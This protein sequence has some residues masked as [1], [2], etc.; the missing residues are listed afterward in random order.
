MNER[1][2]DSLP[3]ASV[4]LVGGLLLGL[5]LG[6]LLGVLLAGTFATPISGTSVPSHGFSTATGC[7]GDEPP[8][9]VGTTPDGDHRSVYLGNYSFTHDSP[10]VDVRST[11]TEGADGAWTLALATTPA[12]T[13]RDVPDDCQPR[14]TVDASVALPTD[15]DSLT[16]T[17]DGERIAAVDVSVDEPQFRSLGE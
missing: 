13:D 8:A 17:L 9:W 1:L 7:A 14:T 4:G 5:L 2:R 3:A 11:L 6:A 10:G 16:I 15:A 12:E